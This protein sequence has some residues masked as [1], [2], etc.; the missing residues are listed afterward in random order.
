[1]VFTNI[2]RVGAVFYMK[3]FVP[4]RSVNSLSLPRRFIKDIPYHAA[5]I[6]PLISFKKIKPCCLNALGF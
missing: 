4:P 6:L 5:Q 2:N 3:K 1:M